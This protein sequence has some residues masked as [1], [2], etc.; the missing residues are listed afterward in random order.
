MDLWSFTAGEMEICIG[1]PYFLEE[2]SFESRE[3][4]WRKEQGQIVRV[5]IGIERKGDSWEAKEW[6]TGGVLSVDG[7]DWN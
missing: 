5:G 7:R 1:S 6:S 3:K 4:G 2:G